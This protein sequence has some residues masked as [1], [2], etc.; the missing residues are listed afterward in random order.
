MSF[1]LFPFHM[2]LFQATRSS[3]RSTTRPRSPPL[4]AHLKN[5]QSG[6]PSRA[7]SQRPIRTPATPP[8]KSRAA[9]K[10]APPAGK[11]VPKA[12]A[13]TPP[14]SRSSRVGKTCVLRSIPLITQNADGRFCW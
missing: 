9:A 5:A 13:K 10:P 8:S 1:L 12:T 7:A 4:P 2:L 11:P 6:P 14:P 3:E